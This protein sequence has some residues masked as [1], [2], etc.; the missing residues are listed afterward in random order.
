MEPIHFFLAH[1]EQLE[2]DYWRTLYEEEEGSSRLS[3]LAVCILVTGVAESVWSTPFH[4]GRFERYIEHVAGPEDPDEEGYHIYRISDAGLLAF[5]DVD[6]NNCHMILY[7]FGEAIK[8]YFNAYNSEEIRRDVLETLV[9][10]ST[11]ALD[12]RKQL[13]LSVL[14]R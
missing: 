12:R 10:L 3:L 8:T 11:M 5:R 6:L 13:Y 2:G 7:H 14:F 9:R 4:E 1:L